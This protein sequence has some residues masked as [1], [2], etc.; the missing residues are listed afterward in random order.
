VTEPVVIVD[1]YGRRDALKRELAGVE[2]TIAR[3]H[4]DWA[5]VPATSFE[6]RRGAWA[7]VTYRT[8]KNCGIKNERVDTTPHGA[9]GEWHRIPP[10]AERLA[11][12]INE[13]D[14]R[15]KANAGIKV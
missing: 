2:V 13:S 15:N 14:D 7:R 4:H 8:C 10:E 1:L 5:Y 11:A 12:V 9:L 3:C 6:D